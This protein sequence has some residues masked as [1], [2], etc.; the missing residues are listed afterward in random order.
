MKTLTVGIATLVAGVLV[1]VGALVA[2]NRAHVA[3]SLREAAAPR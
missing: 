1:L 2:A 3:L